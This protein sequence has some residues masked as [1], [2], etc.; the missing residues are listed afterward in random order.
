M[1]ALKQFSVIGLAVS[2]GLLVNNTADA[3]V[4][5]G[6]AFPDFT[7]AKFTEPSANL[8]LS[9]LKGKVVILDF[10]ASWCE[11]CKVELP[12][13]NK[14]HKKFHAKGLEI[15]GINEDKD[16]VEA[17]KFLKEFPMQMTLLSD[18]QNGDVLKKLEV[19]GLPVTYV[20]DKKGKVSKIHKGFKEGDVQKFEKEVI[21]LLKSK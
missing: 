13:L 17:N 4:K 20:L 1:R 7:L 9:S 12:I 10:W 19:A 14:M 18:G 15:I 11:P 16:V 21:A 5:V 6:Q 3:K 8:K 2:L